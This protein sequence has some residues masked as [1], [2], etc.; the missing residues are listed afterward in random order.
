MVN[1]VAGGNATLGTITDAGLY[2]APGAATTVSVAA[3][4][5]A[6]SSK[7]ASASVSVPARHRIATRSTIAEF[8]DRTTGNVFMPRGNNYVRLA[9]Q[10]WPYGGPPAYHSALNVGLYDANG[11]EAA[12]TM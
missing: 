4:L 3:V 1:G 12:S 9:T 8:F 10:R 2:T 6:D 7:S 11:I 5:Q